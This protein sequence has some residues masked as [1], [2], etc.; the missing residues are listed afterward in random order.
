MT[1]KW[2]LITGGSRG[3]GQALVAELLSTW[4]VVFTG[5]SA[6][7]ISTA[8][9]IVE[10][11]YSSTWVKGFQCDGKDEK[12][13]R[14]LSQFLLSSF[15]APTAIIHNAG[16]TRDGLHLHQDAEIWRDVMDNNLISIIN[17]NRELIPSMFM[18]RYGSIVFMS[19]ITGLKGNIGQTAYAASKAAMMG[20]TRSLAHEVGRFNLRVNCVAPGLIDSDMTK[21][22]PEAKLKTMRQSIPLRRI[23]KPQEVAKLVKFLISEDSEYLTGQTLVLD[24]GLTA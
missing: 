16:I 2:V 11:K 22:M 17:W 1:N 9:G 4:N 6:E 7:G 21:A 19:S 23:G 14:A 15:G 8:V 20:V 10:N 18:A 12:Q 13:V 24:G 5:R 3:I